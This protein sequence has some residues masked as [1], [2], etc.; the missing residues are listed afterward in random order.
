M[1][2][3]LR[4][5][6]EPVQIAED[7]LLRD[8]P[9]AY[10]VVFGG[11]GSQHSL[12]EIP[13]PPFAHNAGPYSPEVA[14]S[15]PPLAPN[16]TAPP[17]ERDMARSRRPAPR[18]IRAGGHDSGYGSNDSSNEGPT[19]P[20]SSDAE[21]RRLTAYKERGLLKRIGRKVSE[22]GELFS[23]FAFPSRCDPPTGC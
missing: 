17:S 15:T 19:S 2:P 21:D 9:P 6:Q 12:P 16:A 20:N 18:T 1:L 13:S 4:Y 8:A 22:E 11:Q 23:T 3:I 10:D 7:E 5:S 14:S